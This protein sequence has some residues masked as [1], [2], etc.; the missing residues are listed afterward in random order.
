[1]GKRTNRSL[2]SFKI[3]SSSRVLLIDGGFRVVLYIKK[4]L[5]EVKNRKIQLK[6]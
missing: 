3:G 2:F 6:N 5:P 4:D 1:M